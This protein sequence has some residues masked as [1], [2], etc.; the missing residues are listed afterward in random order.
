M[1]IQNTTY[2]VR[3]GILIDGTPLR[4]GARV[5]IASRYGIVRRIQH[6]SVK[7]EWENGDLS[8]WIWAGDIAAIL[9]DDSMSKPKAEG[10]GTVISPDGYEVRD[11]VAQESYLV[12]ENTPGYL[13]EADEPAEFSTY[14]EAVDY[15][16]ELADELEADGYTTDRSWASRDNSY[17]IQ[18]TTEAKMH[19]LGRVIE[20]VRNVL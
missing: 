9:R 14:R 16:N 8:S 5:R 7:V 19:D 1:S 12:I 20:V 18:A 10:Y 17:A 3:D 4:K 15:A 11:D 13:P 6:E 2:N